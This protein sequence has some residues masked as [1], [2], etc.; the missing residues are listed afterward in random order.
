[1]NEIVK[2]LTCHDNE[3]EF[4]E[5]QSRI[6]G[7][8]VTWIG[9]G[10]WKTPL[11]VMEPMDCWKVHGRQCADRGIYVSVGTFRPPLSHPSSVL[12][13]TKTHSAPKSTVLLTSMWRA[14]LGGSTHIVLLSHKQ[15]MGPSHMPLYMPTHQ[16]CD[17]RSQTL[18]GRYT[19]IHIDWMPLEKWAP[20]GCMIPFWFFPQQPQ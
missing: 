16:V 5:T 10:Y 4:L 15:P 1:M 12:P 3:L 8:T 13:L 2:G 7:N 14:C 6:T 19:A 18:S 9:L 20:R 11:L 17:P